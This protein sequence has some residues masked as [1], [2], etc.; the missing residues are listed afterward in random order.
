MRGKTYVDIRV[1]GGEVVWGLRTLLAPF[2]GRCLHGRGEDPALL[3]VQVLRQHRQIRLAHL[4]ERRERFRERQVH[5]PVA[6]AAL[7][8]F[9][10]A[11]SNVDA[12]C[13]TQDNDGS[14]ARLR[15]VEQV[16][17]EGLAGVLGEQVEFIYDEDDSFGNLLC[18]FTGLLGGMREQS[19][20]RC[21][22][23]SIVLPHP[24][25]VFFK[26]HFFT[27]LA[28]DFAERYLIVGVDEA[29]QSDHMVIFAVVLGDLRKH[30]VYK[31]SFT[32]SAGANEEH[33][34]AFSGSDGVLDELVDGFVLVVE[35]NQRRRARS[36]DALEHDGFQE[37]QLAPWTQIA[38]ER[39]WAGFLFLD[40]RGLV[41]R[42]W[43]C[44]IEDTSQNAVS[45][46]AHGIS[47]Y[48]SSSIGPFYL[49]TVNQLLL[50]VAHAVGPVCTAS[51]A[52][53]CRRGK[54]VF[55]F[56]H[57]RAP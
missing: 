18:H 20:E 1:P 47:I 45:I 42:A 38:M 17:Q 52:R 39:G 15:N 31:C 12:R 41:E 48:L 19:E 10:Q 29:V 51:H 6:E 3:D 25:S 57:R 44:R 40:R 34:V 22:R 13:E 16:V 21:Q 2:A 32:T 37:I 49:G 50:L 4:L 43:F 53:R 24:T 14:F 36:C 54:L 11:V 26:L 55:R 46:N 8:T 56:W 27:Q 35:S 7:D 5:V 23:V 9:F 33:G 30:R 28:P